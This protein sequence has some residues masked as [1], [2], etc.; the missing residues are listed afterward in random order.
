[1]GAEKE[2]IAWTRMVRSPMIIYAGI[3]TCPKCR[4]AMT[5]QCNLF[6][7]I[8]GADN[9]DPVVTALFTI[10]SIAAMTIRIASKTIKA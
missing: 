8:P 1:M 2:V 9:R 6:Q 7:E 4:W 10:Y 5:S 3:D